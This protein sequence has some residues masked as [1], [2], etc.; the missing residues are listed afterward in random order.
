ML[1]AYGMGLA[2][3]RV[4]REAAVEAPLSAGSGLDRITAGLAEE[5]EAALRAQGMPLRSVEVLARAQVHYD[6]T[7]TALEVEFGPVETMRA[8][9]EAQHRQRFGF[10]TPEKPLVV[11]S[12]AAETVGAPPAG[13]P[14]EAV[15]RRLGRA[16]GGRD[17][18]R[19]LRRP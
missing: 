13:R 17:H 12:L 11:E 1:S 2:D 3:L 5:A 8:A 7:D 19:P 10:I 15:P 14:A 18:A 4:L 6:G 9:F 16:R